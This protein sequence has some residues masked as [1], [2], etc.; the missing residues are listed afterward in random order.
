MLFVSRSPPQPPPPPSSPPPPPCPRWD[1]SLENHLYAIFRCILPVKCLLFFC[2]YHYYYQGREYLSSFN[3]ISYTSYTLSTFMN[4]TQRRRC[5][6]QI[7]HS[8]LTPQSLSWATQ[9]KSKKMMLIAHWSWSTSTPCL[10]KVYLSS[11]HH[12]LLN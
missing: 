1:L 4:T 10:K 5:V 2:L 6:H 3:L 7:V 12:P 9:P 8:K 11:W